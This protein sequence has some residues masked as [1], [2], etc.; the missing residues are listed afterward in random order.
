MANLVQRIFLDH[1]ITNFDVNSLTIGEIACG[2]GSA[3]MYLRDIP[4]K[5]DYYGADISLKII[6]AALK[7]TYIPNTWQVNFFRTTADR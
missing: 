3:I 6:Q 7:R 4:L 2:E 5:V 1:I